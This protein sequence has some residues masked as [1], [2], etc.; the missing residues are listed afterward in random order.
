MNSKNLLYSTRNYIQHLV[1]TYNGKA[2]E[3]ENMYIYMCV[4]VYLHTLIIY[5]I[6]LYI[7]KYIYI[8]NWIALLYTWNIVNQLYILQWK[9]SNNNYKLFKNIHC[10]KNWAGCVVVSEA[11]GKPFS[12]SNWNCPHLSP[13]SWGSA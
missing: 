13:W 1:I 9:I 2:S 12:Q 8:K 3:K 10:V 4:C 7:F 6:H 5:I 11:I